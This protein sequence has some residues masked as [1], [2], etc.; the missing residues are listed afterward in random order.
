MRGKKKKKEKGYKIEENML[1]NITV[2]V[3]KK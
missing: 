2:K 3:K 1:K